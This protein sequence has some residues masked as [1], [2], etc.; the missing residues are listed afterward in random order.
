MAVVLG[1]ATPREGKSLVKILGVWGWSQGGKA[2]TSRSN[3]GRHHHRVSSALGS[4]P[5]TSRAEIL[6]TLVSRGG[7]VLGEQISEMSVGMQG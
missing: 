5:L 7:A 2:P 6:S 1:P 3:P 4:W